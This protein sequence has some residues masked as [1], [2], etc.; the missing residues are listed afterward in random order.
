MLVGNYEQIVKL[1]AEGANLPVEEI[2]R[3]IEARRAKL[4]GLISKEGAAQIIASELGISFDKQ[5]MKISGLLSG[6]KKISITGKIIRMN[7]IAEYNKNGR[8]GKIGSFLIADDTSNIRV[9][10]WDTNH[11]QLIETGAIKE[12]DVIDIAGGDIRNTELH[13]TGFGDIKVSSAVLDNVQTKQVVQKKSIDKI[14]PND[15]VSTRAYIVQLFG[16]TFYSV[17]SECNKKLNESNK[18][19]VHGVVSPKRNAILTLILD[20]G[21]GNIRAVV[22]SDQ[23]KKMATPEQL[24]NS[25]SF[26]GKRQELMGK[27]MIVEGGVRR[28]KL[29]DALEIFVNDVHDVD[30]DILINELEKGN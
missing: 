3:R 25:E 27:E 17:C 11:I 12:G 24:E 16:P 18:C 22:F 10:L 2:E 19:E 20:D 1:V 8:S 23:L 28:N 13:L 5:K 21:S 6:M 29:T 26:M 9:V 15:Q 7:K 30:L 14:Q 4:S